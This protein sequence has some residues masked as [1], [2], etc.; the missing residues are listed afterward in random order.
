MIELSVVY[1]CI[2]LYTAHLLYYLAQDACGSAKDKLY[3]SLNELELD[4]HNTKTFLKVIID[5]HIDTCGYAY[6]KVSIVNTL[7]L[8]LG[9]FFLLIVDEKSFSTEYSKE[10]ES[11]VIDTLNNVTPLL[12][13]E[14]VEQLIHQIVNKASD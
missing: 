14:N 9:I 10:V 2:Y 11:S 4:S 12:D 8:C 6:K 7:W 3:K 5:T 1:F 13:A